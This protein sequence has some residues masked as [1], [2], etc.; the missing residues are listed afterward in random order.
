MF[1]NKGNYF[2]RKRE[3]IIDTIKQFLINLMSLSEI[4]LCYIGTK[5]EMQRSQVKTNAVFYG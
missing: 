4:F 3:E 1:E 2:D 5:R